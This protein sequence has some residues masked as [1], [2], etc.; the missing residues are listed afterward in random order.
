MIKR[1]PQE[2]ADFFQCY[3]AQD[4]DGDWY[5]YKDKPNLQQVSLKQIRCST[6]QKIHML[7]MLKPLTQQVQDLLLRFAVSLLRQYP[8]R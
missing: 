4:E 7:K 3:V 6:L 5:M 8:Q 2:I 1:T